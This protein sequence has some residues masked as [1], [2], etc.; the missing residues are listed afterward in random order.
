MDGIGRHLAAQQ[1]RS[2][3]DWGEVQAYLGKVFD[4]NSQRFE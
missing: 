2:I 1:T 4:G 3:R